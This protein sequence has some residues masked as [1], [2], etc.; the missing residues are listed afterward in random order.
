MPE[1]SNF[2][3]L[4]AFLGVIGVNFFDRKRRRGKGNEGNTLHLP[5]I[6]LQLWVDRKNQPEKYQQEC[7]KVAQALHEYGIVVLK[8][9][10]V[11]EKDNS[12]FIDMLERYFELSDGKRDAR[13]ELAYQVGVTPE[14]TERAR[15][16]C[17]T[18]G[19]YGP[20]DKP[21]TICPPELD[22]K[23]RFFW[24]I[25]P[26]PESTKFPALNAEAVIPPEIPEWA[27]VMDNWG[28]KVSYIEP[29]LIIRTLP[30][31]ECPTCINLAY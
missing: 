25:G 16:F 30:Q 14:K 18:F 5:V 27:S 3:G 9:H 26:K 10:R 28:N 29:Y 22:P 12:T 23:W 17:S 21:L 19:A 4:L 7:Q 31:I 2:F 11:F 1:A 6:D 24:R 15:Q 8:D 13:P 20:D